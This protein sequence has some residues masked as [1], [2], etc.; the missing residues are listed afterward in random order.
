MEQPSYSSPTPWS[1]RKWNSP[2][3]NFFM[4]QV[5][6]IHITMDNI[7]ENKTQNDTICNPQK[8]FVTRGR[9]K[10]NCAVLTSHKERFTFFYFKQNTVG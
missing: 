4:I 1:C 10:R 7:R 6:Y 2:P 8:I 9:E 3:D 5:Y